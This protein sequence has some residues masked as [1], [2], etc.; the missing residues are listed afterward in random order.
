MRASLWWLAGLALVL[1]VAALWH[2]WRSSGARR[3]KVLLSGVALVPFL[4]PMLYVLLWDI[5]D[6][7][8]T[9]YAPTEPPG[10]DL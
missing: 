4:G 8:G 5:P 6:A 7:S 1:T 2:L 10:P 3:V 9:S